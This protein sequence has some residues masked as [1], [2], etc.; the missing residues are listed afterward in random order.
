MA[1][2]Q[3]VYIWI[4]F[5]NDRSL[6]RLK[7]FYYNFVNIN[8]FCHLQVFLLYRGQHASLLHIRVVNTR[9]KSAENM[10]HIIITA[11]YLKF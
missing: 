2:V 1:E 6:S 4:E 5:V 7:I 9:I 8:F 3:L 10:E 11:K